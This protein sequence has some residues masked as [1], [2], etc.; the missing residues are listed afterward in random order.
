MSNILPKLWLA[1]FQNL[2]RVVVY[3]RQVNIETLLEHL[4]NYPVLNSFSE[5]ST[6]SE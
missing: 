1:V 2:N 4:T 6:M 5:S 3:K